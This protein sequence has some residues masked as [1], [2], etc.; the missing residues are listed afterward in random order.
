MGNT[1]R[2]TRSTSHFYSISCH[3]TFTP[4]RHL[5][6]ILLYYLNSLLVFCF[7]YKLTCYLQCEWLLE[8]VLRIIFTLRNHKPSTTL[9]RTVFQ[10][11]IPHF[12]CTVQDHKRKDLYTLQAIGGPAQSS[13]KK[14]SRLS[15]N[16]PHKVGEKKR[17]NPKAKAAILAMTIFCPLAHRYP[18]LEYRLL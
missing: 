2:K 15:G 9:S 11:F 3:R 16:T 17:K 8:R 5:L 12:K 13:C 18:H 1:P 7:P 6:P 10:I 4:S 14:K